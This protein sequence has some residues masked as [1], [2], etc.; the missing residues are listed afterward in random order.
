M[1]A[2]RRGGIIWPLVSAI[3]SP[4]GKRFGINSG[5]RRASR[6]REIWDRG[7]LKMGRVG[8]AGH[9]GKEEELEMDAERELDD[10]RLIEV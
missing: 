8:M 9:G 6:F 4:S 7:I 3:S 5:Y 10:S 2:R 1:S